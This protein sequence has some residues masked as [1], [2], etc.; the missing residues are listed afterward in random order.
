MSKSSL[1][2]LSSTILSLQILFGIL[3]YKV[4]KMNNYFEKYVYSDENKSSVAF[5]LICPG[6]AFMVFGM[7][8]INLGLT[9]NEV[10]TKYSVGYFILMI[11]FIYVQFKTIQVFFVLKKKFQF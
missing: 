9:Y 8:F 2:T 4:M 10:L 1:F 7:F 3:G 5:A 11:P 6:V